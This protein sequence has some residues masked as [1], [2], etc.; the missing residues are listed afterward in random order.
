MEWKIALICL[1]GLFGLLLMW[2]FM[3]KPLK[4]VYHL[5]S[6]LVIGGVLL[7]VSNFLLSQAGLRVAL[8]PVT[9]L[10]AGVLQVPGVILLA[11]LHHIFV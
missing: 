11:V 7:Y 6:Y 4:L 8:N 10:T 5:V 9:M 3:I 1:A 2:P